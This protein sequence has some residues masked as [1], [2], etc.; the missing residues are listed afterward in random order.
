[1]RRRGV[2]TALY[3]AAAEVAFSEGF[4]LCSDEATSLNEEAEAVW[5]SLSEKGVAYWEVPGDV[6]ENFDYGRYVIPRPPSR[7]S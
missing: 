2:A 6:D 3:L 7:K 4:S 1:M 5:V